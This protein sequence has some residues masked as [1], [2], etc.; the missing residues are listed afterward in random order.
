MWRWHVKIQ[1]MSKSSRKNTFPIGTRGQKRS[2][3]PKMSHISRNSPVVQKLEQLEQNHKKY[4]KAHS[5]GYQSLHIG[6]ELKS[7]FKVLE[8]IKGQNSVLCENSF[9][10]INQSME[11]IELKRSSS[12]RIHEPLILIQS[13]PAD[14]PESESSPDQSG[15][16]RIGI[17]QIPCKIDM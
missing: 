7:V 5:T 12:I 16:N 11:W 17:Y 14:D 1:D 6:F 13:N 2:N 3:F 10:W 15:H 9:S 4:L 8:V